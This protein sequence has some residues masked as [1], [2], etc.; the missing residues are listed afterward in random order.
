VVFFGIWIVIRNEDNHTA[1]SLNEA[2]TQYEGGFTLIEML[3]TLSVIAILSSMFLLS[4]RN[5]RDDLALQHSGQLVVQAVDEARNNAL[6]NK[7][8][9]ALGSADTPT[10]SPGGHGIRFAI[11]DNFSTLF[12]DCDND[13]E[14]DMSGSAPSCGEASTLGGY[15]EIEKITLLRPG[16]TI[17][18]INNF[19][20]PIAAKLDVVFRPPY[21]QPEFEPPL[22]GCPESS[23]T[24][25]NGSGSS[26]VIFINELGITRTL[27][28]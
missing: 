6:A 22:A 25:T 4:A 18:G 20:C 9:A 21:P 7:E 1:R 8:H 26:L 13:T 5:N 3:V 10:V 24:L 15:P 2:P 11:G 28:L 23:V 16:V 17:T 27:S 14:L 19:G 12:A